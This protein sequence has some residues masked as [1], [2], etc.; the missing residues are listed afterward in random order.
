MHL[1]TKKAFKQKKIIFFHKSSCRRHFLCGGYFVYMRKNKT[2]FVPQQRASRLAA[3]L[4]AESFAA[5]F[6]L[7]TYP[8]LYKFEFVR[9]ILFWGETR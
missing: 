7:T 2:T 6:F 1:G 5:V 8:K 9:E 3:R 4:D